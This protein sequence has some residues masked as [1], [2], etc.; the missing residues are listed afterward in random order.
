MLR[1]CSFSRLTGDAG[2]V[3]IAMVFLDEL[4]LR[5][6][7]F[8]SHRL[9]LNAILQMGSG[10]SLALLGLLSL[11]QLASCATLLIPRL[12]R[13]LGTTVPSMALGSTLA[14]EMMLYHGFNDY[15]LT[16]K[17]CIIWLSLFLIGLLRNH[18]YA[19]SASMG[20]PLSGRALAFEANIRWACTK[21]RAGLTLSPIVALILFRAIV[22]NCFWSYTGTAFEIRRTTFLTS[23]AQCALMLILSSE[24]KSSSV[25]AVHKIKNKFRSH[26]YNRVFKAVYGESP[27]GRKNS[28]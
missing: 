23:V 22:F 20:V 1:D 13:H 21:C 12:Y 2:T 5:W 19:K 17:A 7:N 16:L 28:L 26:V 9:Y 27:L 14:L 6:L 4:R 3:L 18:R 8:S 24:D 10:M 11:A 25:H 15:E